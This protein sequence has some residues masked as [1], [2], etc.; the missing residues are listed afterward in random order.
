MTR[1]VAILTLTRFPD[2][3]E[4]LADSIDKHEDW[5]IR[6][7]VVTSG[8]AHI[9]QCNAPWEVVEGV[10]PFVFA[11]NVN[12]GLAHIGPDY[13][14]LLV[15]DDC[16]FTMPLVGPLSHLASTND[17]IG[18]IAPEVEGGVGNPEQRHGAERTGDVKN[19][20]CFVCV[21]LPA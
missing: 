13:D 15:N 3:F 8:G 21:Y 12:R 10:E 16:E 6:R 17:T 20:I 7:V 18:I 5:G 9:E 1:K 14:V 4:R 2:I 11:R 19:A